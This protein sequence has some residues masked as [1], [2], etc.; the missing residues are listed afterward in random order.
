MNVG[1][2]AVPTADQLIEAGAVIGSFHAARHAF[3]KALTRQVEAV[4]GS[5]LL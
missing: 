3:V 2:G 1:D 5:A 4:F